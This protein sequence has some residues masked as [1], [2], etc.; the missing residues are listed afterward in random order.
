MSRIE[1]S[2][3]RNLALAAL[4]R[5]Q[6]VMHAVIMRDMRSRFFNNGLGFVV[7]CLWPLAHL[8]IIMVINIVA[9]RAAPYGDPMLFFATG[10]VPVLTFIYISRFMSLSLLMNKPMLSFPIVQLTDVLFGRAILEVFAGCVSLLFLWIIF[11]ALGVYY[12]PLDLSE[13]LFAYLATILLAVGVGMIVG[14]VSMF[15]PMFATIYALMGILFYI[16]SGAL[17]VVSNLP[18]QLAIPM[19]YSPVVQCVE[20][21][22]VAYFDNY[23]DK[24]L[25]RSYLVFVG[26][27]C[28]FIGLI[29]ERLSRRIM[30]D[31]M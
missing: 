8:L 27:G 14:V 5:K 20:W 19:S 30:L 22:R 25:D 7:Q 28:L 23:S 2:S 15:L 4:K 18:D 10:L 13:A 9:G 6:H 24:L 31:E 21:M 1:K 3:K 17:F 12:Y 29:A 26:C 16:S 11:V